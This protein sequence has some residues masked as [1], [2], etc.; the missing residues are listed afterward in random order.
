MISPFCSLLGRCWD[1]PRA[2]SSLDSPEVPGRG[3]FV[4][5]DPGCHIGGDQRQ[6]CFFVSDVIF[7]N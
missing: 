1:L 7:S 3:N 6:V 4:D 2:L 5:R